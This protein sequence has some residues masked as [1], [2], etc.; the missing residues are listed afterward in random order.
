MSALSSILAFTSLPIPK[1]IPSCAK[2]M[3]VLSFPVFASLVDVVNLN[4]RNVST[5]PLTSAFTVLKSELVTSVVPRRLVICSGP[6]IM[7]LGI[8]GSTL[9]ESR[10]CLAVLNLVIFKPV[11]VP[12]LAA[13]AV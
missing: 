3:T 10:S 5:S 8:E 7:C 1:V 4:P 2:A 12:T 6:H 13:I 11:P 9:A